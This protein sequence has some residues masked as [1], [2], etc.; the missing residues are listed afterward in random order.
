MITK[1]R[2]HD[3]DRAGKRLLRRALES[4]DWVVNDVQ[5]DYGIDSNVQV[6]D[7]QSPTGAW[8]HVQLKSSTSSEYSSDRSFV[9]QELPIDHARHYALEMLDPVFLVHADVTS[10][11]IY[12]CAIQL[13]TKLAAVLERAGAQFARIRIPTS[14]ELPGTAPGLLVAL[15]D[16]HLMLAAR[17]LT[18]AP[19]GSFENTFKRM[20]NQEALHR[21]FQDKANA[22]KLRKI[23][24]IA[25]FVGDRAVE[26]AASW[27]SPRA[28]LSH[29]A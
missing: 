14:Q 17:E 4:L 19:I 13:D 29:Y 6:F 15:N 1:P 27:K 28:G 12:W 24:S 18:G 5:E 16:I 25:L 22:L 20:P 11:K 3:I 21:A 23:G 2:Q 8:F 7:K 9:S 26:K 10:E